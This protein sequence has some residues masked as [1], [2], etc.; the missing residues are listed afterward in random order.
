[1]KPIRSWRRSLALGVGTAFGAAL[2]AVVITALVF[3]EDPKWERAMAL[4]V[5]A[6][7]VFTV[8]ERYRSPGTTRRRRPT[9]W[10]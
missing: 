5:G 2:T 8:L 10:L 7:V 6:S 3:D 9:R 4:A 1:M